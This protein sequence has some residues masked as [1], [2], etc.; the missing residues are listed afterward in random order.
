VHYNLHFFLKSMENSTSTAPERELT[1]D[2]ILEILGTDP[3]EVSEESFAWL[4]PAQIARLSP[5]QIARLSPA[6]I[7][8]LSPDQIAKIKS[9]T[10]E[11][12]KIAPM[13]KPYSKI[14]AAINSEGCKLN[15]STWHSCDTVHCEAGWT[16]HL[17]P[18]GYK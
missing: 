3:R 11:F 10:D 7:A 17:H 18:D 4:S 12:E 2:E 8:W 16:V 6:Q 1:R 13:E 5:D 15:M 14:L 9:V